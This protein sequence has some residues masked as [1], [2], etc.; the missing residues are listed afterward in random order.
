MKDNIYC[1]GIVIIPKVLKRGVHV[2]RGL[3]PNIVL[4]VL[5]C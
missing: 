2:L 4:T 1:E 3:I 5:F